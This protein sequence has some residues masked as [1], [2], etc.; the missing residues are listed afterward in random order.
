MNVTC[1]FSLS[2]VRH[3]RRGVVWTRGDIR[4]QVPS[5]R[6]K[7]HAYPRSPSPIAATRAKQAVACAGTLLP[8]KMRGRGISG[9]HV[10]GFYP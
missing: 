2:K 6:L 7:R 3:C 8:F 10:S 4:P 9:S 5:L 1:V